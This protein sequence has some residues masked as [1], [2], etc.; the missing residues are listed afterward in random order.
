M[1]TCGALVSY[2]SYEFAGRI[3]S[4]YCPRHKAGEPSRPNSS[5]D[6]HGTPHTPA[7]TTSQQHTQIVLT[8]KTEQVGART[9]RLTFA[10]SVSSRVAST[11]TL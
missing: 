3:G 6:K 11:K 8:N 4:Q 5:A 1:A 10:G 9:K 7:K 2:A